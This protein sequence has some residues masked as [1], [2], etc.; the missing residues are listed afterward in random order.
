M[1]KKSFND[2]LKKYNYQVLVMIVVGVISLM[3]VAKFLLPKKCGEGSGRIQMVAEDSPLKSG[4]RIKYSCW[5][6]MEQITG[7]VLH[8]T[9]TDTFQKAKD[10]MEGKDLFVQIMVD[11]DGKSYQLT[12]NLD[13]FAAGA[14]GA[15]SWAIN[16]EIVGTKDSLAKSA[17]EHDQQFRSVIAVLKYLVK[18]Y[19]IP[20]NY[21]MPSDG[22]IIWHGIF[23]HQIVDK[24]HPNGG[25]KGKTDPGDAYMKEIMAFM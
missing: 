2:F 8:S 3:I 14:T 7:I 19:K 16:I 25:R 24:Y 11:K 12:D 18:K 17:K 15:N 4:Q 6:K 20:L 9:E 21:A 1:K 13:D 10:V 5:G 22:S 23:S